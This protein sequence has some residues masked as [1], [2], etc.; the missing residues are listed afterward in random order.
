MT[1]V[2]NKAVTDSNELTHTAVNGSSSVCRN[3]NEREDGGPS[4]TRSNSQTSVTATEI[5]AAAQASAKPA[6]RPERVCK[7]TASTLLALSFADDRVTD[8]N[9]F[10]QAAA[11]AATAAEPA[12]AQPTATATDNKTENATDKLPPNKPSCSSNPT[13]PKR[14]AKKGQ[15]LAGKKKKAK[16]KK[17]AGAKVKRGSQNKRRKKKVAKKRVASK[18][19]ENL[20]SKCS[21]S[22]VKKLRRTSVCSS[23]KTAFIVEQVRRFS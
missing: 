21:S 15:S 3:C 8:L 19:E 17:S 16:S 10:K 12:A 4:E 2:V 20:Q 7:N 22:P 1:D 13:V 11:K 6:G 5:E 14:K 9:L 23:S 18:T